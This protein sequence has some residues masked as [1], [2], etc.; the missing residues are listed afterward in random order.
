[1]PPAVRRT[2]ADDAAFR[3]L[4]AELDADLHRRY[5]RVQDAYDGFNIL[6]ADTR[7]VIVVED[8]TPLG[9]GCIKLLEPSTV[10]IKRMFVSPHARRRGIARTVMN[11]LETWARELGATTALLETGYLQHEA[12]ALY[13]HL[14]YD[15]TDPFGPYAEPGMDS[16]VCMRKAL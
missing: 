12:I 13:E 10:E 16:S 7:T 5:D 8:G 11:A 3:T 1:M 2:T 14:G 9:C 15:R 6:P 4:V